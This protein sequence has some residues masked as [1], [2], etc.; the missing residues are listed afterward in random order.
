MSTTALDLPTNQHQ[1]PLQTGLSESGRASIVDHL[2]EILADHYL[3]MLKTHNYHWNVRGPLFK[4][5]HDLTESQYE[6]LFGAIDEIAERI[7][8][9]G[10]DAPGSFE[11]YSSLS[12]IKEAKAGISALE[13][14]A[15]LL[16]SHENI[17][18]N[19]REA[20][21]VA[22]QYED[23]VSIDMLTER[24]KVHEKAAWMWRS[25]NEK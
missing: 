22:D 14:A 6:D 5:M 10:F 9:L 17:I 12:K 23:E 21:A 2:N 4:S 18:R 24:L 3:L 16:A 8:A 19:M 25:F 15:D 11:A 20:L 7:R 1:V 13:M